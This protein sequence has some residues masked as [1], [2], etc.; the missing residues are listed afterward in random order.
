MLSGRSASCVRTARRLYSQILD[1]IEDADYDVFS[2][3]VRVPTWRKIAMA[4]SSLAAPE[5][6]DGRLAAG[7]TR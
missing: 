7:T 6:R 3:R 5:Q 4:A 1:R 2:G